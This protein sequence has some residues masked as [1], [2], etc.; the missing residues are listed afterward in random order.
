MMVVAIKSRS[1]SLGASRYGREDE[2]S[3]EGKLGI[4]CKLDTKVYPD[5]DLKSMKVIVEVNLIQALENE[6]VSEKSDTSISRG[7]W[8]NLFRV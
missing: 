4:V 6:A 5:E 8:A 2:V 3:F 7:I 1:S